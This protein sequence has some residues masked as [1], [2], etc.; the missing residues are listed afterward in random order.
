LLLACWLPWFLETVLLTEKR[1]AAP[2]KGQY[3]RS[4]RQ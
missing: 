3:R 4:S 1:Q 2:K